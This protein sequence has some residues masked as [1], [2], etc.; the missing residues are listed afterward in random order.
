MLEEWFYFF[1][2]MYLVLLAILIGYGAVLYFSTQFN[3]PILWFFIG[4]FII[5]IRM[6][7]SGFDDAKE[8]KKLKDTLKTHGIQS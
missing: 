3:N 1:K 4:V 7:K 8:I 6:L 2:E 5:Q